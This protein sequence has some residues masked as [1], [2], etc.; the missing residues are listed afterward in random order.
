MEKLN[1][2]NDTTASKKKLSNINRL[3]FNNESSINNKIV[4]S[5]YT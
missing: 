3:H 1:I 5:A 2:D 4:I